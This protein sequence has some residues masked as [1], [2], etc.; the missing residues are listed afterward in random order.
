MSVQLQLR[1]NDA[2]DL[3]VISACL[4]D[5]LIP[6]ADM[7]FVP[8]ERRFLLV[9][10]RFRWEIVGEQTQAAASIERVH[11]GVCFE[12]V[13]TVRTRGIDRRAHGGRTLELLTVSLEEN[14]IRLIF[15]GRAEVRLELDG[16]LCH[17]RDFGEPWPAFR[18]PTH[19]LEEHG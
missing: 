7:A 19:P 16:V 4:Q 12:H 3:A 1:A 6:L 13:V 9:A 18:Q 10:S 5:A 8:E 17:L 11:C 15:A 14:A 2:E